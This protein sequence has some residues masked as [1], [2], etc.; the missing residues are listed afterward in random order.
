MIESEYGKK[1][2]FI[3]NRQNGIKAIMEVNSSWGIENDF[4]FRN[5]V[6]YWGCYPVQDLV[7]V[8]TGAKISCHYISME[9]F[10]K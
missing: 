1:D 6:F 7:Y 10:G 5:K 2:T 3:I 9:V 8:L 4:F